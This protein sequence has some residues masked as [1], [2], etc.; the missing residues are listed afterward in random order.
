MQDPIK[1]VPTPD[2]KFHDGNPSTGELGTIVSADWLNTVQSALQATQQEVLSVIGSNNGQKA[3]PARQD[4]L[5]QAIKQLAWGGNAKPTTL[6]GYGIADG[7]TLRPQ[8]G[9]KVDLN[10]IA[11]DGLYHNPG[12]AY[13]ANGTNYPA[14]YAGLLFVFADGEMVYQQYQ[15]YNNAGCW[16]RCRYR[17]NWTQWQKLADAATTLAG[18]GI[19]DG[20]TKAELKAAVDGLVS[21]APGALNTLQELAA[22]LGNDNNFAT[23][24]TN[25]LAGKADKS[26]SLSGYGINTLALSTAQTAQII[27]TTPNVYDG[28]IYT[29]GTLELRSTGTDFP[30]I[31]LHRPG[32]TAVA[33]VHKGH[34][35]DLLV[36]KENSGE[37]YRVWHSGN[38]NSIIK[39][40][41][42]QLHADD[43]TSLDT[44]ITAGEM[45]FNYGTS[46]NVTGP[47]IAFGGL[48]DV[49]GN[50]NYSCQLTADYSSGYVMRFRTR[51]D[52][53]N[54]WNP[55]HTLVHEDSSVLLAKADKASTLAGYG[56][57]DA[58]SKNEL[59]AAVDGVISP[60]NTLLTT[61]QT[62]AI[63]K[64][65]PNQ[66]DP[67]IYARGTMMLQS[68]G[69]DFPSLGLHRPGKSAVALVHKNYGPETLVLKEA[70]GA[71]YRVWHSGNFNPGSSLVQDIRLGAMESV[72]IW[73]GPGYSDTAGYVITGVVNGNTDAFPDVVQRRPLQKQ[74]N[75]T[76]YTISSI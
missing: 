44:S 13:A 21:G 15:S 74:I 18:Y 61:A 67:N 39:R 24:I 3:D 10:N 76:W 64:T 54:R 71:E 51:N 11:D 19:T 12:N 50:L 57:T 70:S 26:S 25:K 72:M 55:W 47:Y 20:A 41:R 52:D 30:S 58:A 60:R 1:P 38:D 66:Y 8:L 6:A 29:N 68:T 48:G 4:Q 43:K 5:L 9:D 40:R 46:S 17:G 23:T 37:E 49:N 28:N 56:I 63:V 36:L 59:N 2:Q 22:A 34:G 69:D 16:Y 32:N 14:P 53:A 35:N 62:T 31:G 7:L 75:G 27:K 42:T 73:N 45:G 65:T 33:L